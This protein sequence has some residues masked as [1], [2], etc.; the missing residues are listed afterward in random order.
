MSNLTN[1]L[2]REITKLEVRIMN[3]KQRLEQDQVSLEV[4]EADLVLWRNK[5]KELEA[6]EANRAARI[7]GEPEVV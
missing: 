7:S 2:Q 5:L 6:D 4:L 1:M 3:K